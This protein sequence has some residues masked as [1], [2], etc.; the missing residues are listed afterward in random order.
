MRSGRAILAAAAF[1]AAMAGPAEALTIK[2]LFK[3][4]PLTYSPNQV[5]QGAGTIR[6]SADGY[7]GPFSVDFTELSMSPLPSPPAERLSYGLY[8]PAASP[9]YELSLDGT[10]EGANEVLSGSFAAGGA[11]RVDIDYAALVKPTVAAFKK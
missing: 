6:V 11:T 9:T 10:P 8:K 3:T 7:V 2:H 4:P 1:A 5:A